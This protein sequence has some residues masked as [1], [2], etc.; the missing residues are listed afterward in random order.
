[1][2]CRRICD[3]RKADCSSTKETL[4]GAAPSSGPEQE[5]TGALFVDVWLNGYR[6]PHELGNL[7]HKEERKSIFFFNPK[8]V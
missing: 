8:H 1:M 2:V 7:L 4:P 3:F 6:Q 5:G